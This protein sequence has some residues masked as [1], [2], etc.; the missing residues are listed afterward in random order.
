MSP[1]HISYFSD[2]LC[3]W[4]YISQI[5]LDEL[6]TQLSD[7]IE[8]SYNFI[9]LFG[10]TKSRIGKGWSEK[11]GYHGFSQHVLEVCHNFPGVD[12]NPEVWSHCRPHSSATTHLF[13]KAVQ[14]LEHESIIDPKITQNKRTLFEELT[15]NVRCAFFR[16]ARDI[17]NLKILHELAESIHLPIA[18]IEQRMNNGAAM[19][20]LCCDMAQKEEHRLEGSPT[21]LL[22][23][24]RQKLFGNVGYR[25]IE[26]NVMELLEKPQDE[27]S[28]C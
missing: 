14:L 20:A 23:E 22:N 24:G 26:A 18:E 11:G 28:W 17:S 10:C 15:W 25:I 1:I 7:R 6:K 2:V 16:D 12:I 21:W 19:A 9:N 27:A 3:V 5:R 13:L 8:I 4:A